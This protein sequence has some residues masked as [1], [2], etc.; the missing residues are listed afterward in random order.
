MAKTKSGYVYL[1]KSNNQEGVYKVGATRL[2]PEQRCAKVNYEEKKKGNGVLNFSVIYFE[3]V[4]DPFFVES[5]IK[6][7]ILDCGMCMAS[8]VFPIYLFN[9]SELGLVDKFKKIVIKA[10]KKG[11]RK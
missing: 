1:L 4:A 7:S 9:G 6:G 5:C 3:R 2:T 8:E 10:T 11:R